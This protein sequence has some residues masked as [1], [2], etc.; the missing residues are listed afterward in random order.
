MPTH[1]LTEA[2]QETLAVF[3]SAAPLTTQ[4]VTEQLDV[5]RRSTYARLERL[6]DQHQLIKT[7]QVGASA[8]VWWRP[9]GDDDVQTADERE[10]FASLVEAVEEY[11][12]FRLDPDGY[13]RTWNNGAKRIKGYEADDILGEHFST[14]YTEDDI[15]AG[16]PAQNLKNAA[17]DGTI[18]DEGFRVR[19]DD[20][21][22]W[23]SV[24]ITPISD[25]QGELTGYI[26]VTRDLTDRRQYEE[27]LRQQRD[28]IEG[29]LETVPVG[30]VVI[31]RD[32]SFRTANERALE[33]LQIEPS[34]DTTYNVGIKAVYNE[35][36]EFLPP[37][38]RPYIQ[39]FETGDSYRNW[40]AQIEL[41]DGTRRW[42]S[43]NIEPLPDDDG[44]I[45]QVLVAIENISQLK[46]QADRLERQ[47]DELR[48]ELN[49]I[50]KR[51]EE[52]FIA[53][54]TDWRITYVN[55][56]AA[57]MVRVSIGELVG[58][59]VWDVFPEVAHG[60]VRS[61]AESAMERQEPFE[62]E[63]Q[64]EILEIW[65]EI[66]GFPSNSGM[67][68]YFR[69]ITERKVR[70]TE[71]QQTKAQLESATNAGR[72]GVWQRNIANDQLFIGEGFTEI[73]GLDRTQGNE[74]ISLQEVLESIHEEDRQRIETAIDEAISS[75]GTY[76]E[77]YRIRTG[78]GE[79]RWVIDRGIVECDDDE[80]PQSFSGALTDITVRKRSELELERQRDRLATLYGINEGVLQ[81]AAAVISDATSDEIEQT[82]CD[83]L[84]SSN[85]FDFAWFAGINGNSGKREL[86]T[87]PTTVEPQSRSLGGSID[88]LLSSTLADDTKLSHQGVRVVRDRTRKPTTEVQPQEDMGSAINAI[89]LVPI[90]YKNID[91]GVLGIESTRETA[92]DGTE[93]DVI[94]R[95]GEIVG[96]SIAANERKQAL[97][98][99]ELIEIE[100]HVP[101]ILEIFDCNSSFGGTIRFDQ[102]T[103]V[104]EGTYVAYG[105]ISRK[106]IEDIESMVEEITHWE[107]FILRSS[108][109]PARFELHVRD[110][111][112]FTTIASAEGYIESLVIEEGDLTV[113]LHLPTTVNLRRTIEEF[114]TVF[115]S[116]SV[117]RKKQI[118]HRHAGPQE[119]Y[120]NIVGELTD[121]QR[122]TLEAAYHA[123]FFEWPRDAQGVEIAESLDIAPAT[124][125]QH[126]RTA[127]R[128][129]LDVV[130]GP[131]P[132]VVR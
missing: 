107:Q 96:H 22:F 66:R 91:Y 38:E 79:L 35:D 90:T 132:T 113:V 94:A 20:T 87:T 109:D 58:A 28:Y 16:V 118:E 15:E 86:E 9:P 103:P 10:A 111:L 24:T 45:N 114:D 30:V 124:F 41:D 59:R 33:L 39:A 115:P 76:E 34:E 99:D 101:N 119:M 56:H 71:L 85:A 43:T 14:F 70:E 60:E 120:Q 11:A 83:A 48:D 69:D 54:D 50:F 125:S 110:S 97:L 13:I 128:K 102:I 63:F 31:E 131:N 57:E 51:T 93:Q 55:D 75:C 52:A 77:E 26:K 95:L 82:V 46:K 25:D 18:E 3:D 49:E 12:I 61:L 72:I 44:S 7:K 81:V 112:I 32:G 53:L 92:F 73:W 98:S 2:L 47:R 121:R 88:D 117:V 74:S 104:A 80:N 5:G 29:I 6:V 40:H 100:Y 62:F 23:A 65:V 105:G 37:S 19:S 68:I 130:L 27:S 89:A 21:Y 108:D 106:G 67:S 122:T 1:G 8:R 129:L 78:D 4:E 123:G 84:S 127:E 126:L 116:G 36:G 42:L 64:S 17:A